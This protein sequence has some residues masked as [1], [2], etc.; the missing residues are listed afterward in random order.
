MEAKLKS[1]PF[2]GWKANASWRSLTFII[3]LWSVGFYVSCVCGAQGPVKIS[4]KSAI[5]AW[6][7]RK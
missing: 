6:N 7:I 5:E 1:C 3:S 4:R 2:C